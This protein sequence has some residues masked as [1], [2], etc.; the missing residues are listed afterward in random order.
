MP[1]RE[2]RWD[3]PILLEHFRR[4]HERKHRKRTLGFTPEAL[5]ALASSAW[6]GNVRDLAR[7]C[8]LFVIH[9]QPGGADRPLVPRRGPPVRA[10]APPRPP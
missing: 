3:I 7:A 1:L 2:R 4:H 10:R 8:A 6:P 9:A 5:R